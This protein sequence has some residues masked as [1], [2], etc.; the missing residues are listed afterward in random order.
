MIAAIPLISS[1]WNSA[2]SWGICA[3]LPWH[4]PTLLRSAKPQ[5]SSAIRSSFR[6]ADDEHRRRDPEFVMSNVLI[7]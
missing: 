4:V 6:N 5:C 1:R 7:R 2:R 3:E